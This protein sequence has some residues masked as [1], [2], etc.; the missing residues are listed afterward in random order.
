MDNSIYNMFAAA[1]T[2]KSNHPGFMVLFRDRSGGEHEQGPYSRG[3]AKMV[4]DEY[5]RF[6]FVAIE[7]LETGEIILTN[8]SAGIA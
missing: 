7:D 6:P 5:S 3:I 2:T 8:A 4:A 1:V